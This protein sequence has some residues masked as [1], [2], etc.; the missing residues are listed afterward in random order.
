M[1]KPY[2]VADLAFVVPTKDRPT[3]VEKLLE[4]LFRQTQACGRIVV[5]DGGSSV[6]HVISGFRE[7]L[8]IDYIRCP[9]PSQ[10]RQRNMGIKA[11]EAKYRLVGFLDDKI[12]L[13]RDALEK[14]VE[15]WNRVED[16][17]AAVGF[18]VTN[19]N[20]AR[21]FPL[22]NL[23]FMSSAAPGRILKSGYNA[24]I[25]NV[26]SDVRSQWLAGGC[27]VWRSD[28]LELFPQEELNTRWAIGED[29]RYSYPIGKKYPLYICAGARCSQVRVFDQASQGNV[30]F[31]RGRKSVISQYYF[32][33]LHTEDFSRLAC[34]WMLLGKC[35]LRFVSACL[36]ADRH[37]LFRALGEAEG[38]L[39]CLHAAIT[40]KQLRSQLEN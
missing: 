14:M 38:F 40:S 7:R 13:E 27:T 28:I 6:E 10:I 19:N 29:L 8:T 17:T 4:S 21:Y 12:V 30:H 9:A 26:A 37:L 2:E 22:Q 3:H 24:S 33:Q 34:L 35:T 31:Y 11:L 15:F 1:R 39:V 23:F 36:K 25:G 20:P 5:I 16:D 32:V 18:N